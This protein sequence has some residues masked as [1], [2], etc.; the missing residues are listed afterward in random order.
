LLPE[1]EGKMPEDR[2]KCLNI[3]SNYLSLPD[4]ERLN[5]RLG[6][7]IGYYEKLSDLNHSYKHG[8]IDEAIKHI[9]SDGRNVDE[10]ITR[11]KDNFI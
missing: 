5:F 3:I 6:R 11:L 2:E 9:R 7:R 1:V 4:H 10:V 8:K